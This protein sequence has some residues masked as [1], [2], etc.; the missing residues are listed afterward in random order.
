MARFS[1]DRIIQMHGNRT[2]GPRGQI[3][4]RITGNT[5]ADAQVAQAAKFNEIDPRSW[6]W[7]WLVGM[8]KYVHHGKYM[9]NLCRCILCVKHG[10]CQLYCHVLKTIGWLLTVGW[11][12]GWFGRVHW[13]GFSVSPVHPSSHGMF[14][15]G[16]RGLKLSDFYHLKGLVNP[17][18]LSFKCLKIRLLSVYVGIPPKPQE[19]WY[20][21]IAR[22]IW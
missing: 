1:R 21:C 11:I 18:N 22:R 16:V 13:I 15:F 12:V 9:R 10:R 2:S 7:K 20:S 19:A 5:G 17:K 8:K 3:W 4:N 14:V 6:I